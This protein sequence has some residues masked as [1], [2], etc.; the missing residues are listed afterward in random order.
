[1]LNISRQFVESSVV[2][3]VSSPKSNICRQNFAELGHVEL[4]FAAVGPSEI[5]VLLKNERDVKYRQLVKKID[6]TCIDQPRMF[7]ITRSEGPDDGLQLR[8]CSKI[9]QDCEGDH[10]ICLFIAK[11]VITQNHPRV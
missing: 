7:D 8:H 2:R 11:I 1:M 6:Q 9:R 10:L 3:R 4:K 5:L